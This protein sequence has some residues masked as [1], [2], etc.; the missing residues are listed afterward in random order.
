MELETVFYAQMLSHIVL[1]VLIIQPV[2]FAHLDS[3]VQLALLALQ[4]SLII[5]EYVTPVLL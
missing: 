5:V 2:L 3:K 1:N 4:D